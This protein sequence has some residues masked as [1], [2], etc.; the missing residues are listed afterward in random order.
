MAKMLIKYE[1]KLSAPST[2]LR[3]KHKQGNAFKEFSEKHFD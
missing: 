2:L 3:V 1:T